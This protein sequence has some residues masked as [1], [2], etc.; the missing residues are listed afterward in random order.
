MRPAT[1]PE[2]RALA[3]RSRV[4]QRMGLAAVGVALLGAPAALAFGAWAA[5]A[6]VVAGGAL[7]V[8][9]ARAAGQERGAYRALLKEMKMRI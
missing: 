4:T 5:A 6:S 2:V 8:A 1:L 3:R 9:W 7:T